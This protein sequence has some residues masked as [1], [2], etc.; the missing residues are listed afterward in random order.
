MKKIL[1]FLAILISV[2]FSTYPSIKTVNAE[3]SYL[4]VITEDTPFYSDKN[5]EELLFYLPYTYYVKILEYH[6]EYAHV[7]CYGKNSVAID[8]YVP[9]DMLFYDGLP[10]INPFLDVKINTSIPAVLYAD[11]TLKTAIQYV[12]P[13]RE[14]DYYGVFKGETENLYFVGYNGKLGYVRESEIIP[15]VIEN[16]PNE[17]TFIEPELPTTEEI[18]QETPKDTGG[19]NTDYSG[20]RIAIIVCLCV[21]GIIALFVA[22]KKKPDT[23]Q[24][25]SGYYDEND[26]E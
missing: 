5:G 24:V 11:K 17:L 21:A 7:E 1:I 14:L 6:N 10:V 4:R 18:P 9:K 19:N 8:G 13:S 2:F 26:Y 12:F 23:S 15:F 3:N 20:L 16:H 22:I 25:A